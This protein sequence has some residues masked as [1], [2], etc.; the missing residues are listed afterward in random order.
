MLIH[1]LPAEALEAICSF[2]SGFDAFSLSHTSSWWLGHLSDS[3]FWQ[4]RL[5][6]AP[7]RATEGEEQ[8]QHHQSWKRRYVQTQSL[9]F[10]GTILRPQ[11]QG[12]DP[13]SRE[14]AWP[15]CF[16]SP[17]T[18]LGHA[19]DLCTWHHQR[20][21]S[22]DTWFCLLPS[23]TGQLVG[24][25]IYGQQSD[26]PAS[27]HSPYYYQQFAIV[28]S[29]CNLYCSVL[30]DTKIVASDLM[31]NRWYH[32]ALTYDGD[33]QSQVVYVD[34]VNVWAKEGTLHRDWHHLM[35]QQVGTGYL[36][37]HDDFPRR[38]PFGWYT[39]H[40]LIDHFRVWHGVLAAE[41]IDAIAHGGN[42]RQADDLLATL[43]RAED[44]SAPWVN[45][46]PVRCSRPAERHCTLV[47]TCRSPPR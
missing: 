42:P 17:T 37:A 47:M 41:A 34:G 40:G 10:G 46:R 19:F 4:K 9:L 24:G 25:V 23:S 21:F 38:D 35:Y 13:S 36:A 7:P 22:F 32:L 12:D 1:L 29:K 18:G 44:G 27:G 11:W 6:K 16:P 20:S 39:F 31:V 2:L 33:R 14:F 28:D 45:A 5:L 3:S 43:D 15:R 8:G 26:K 30:D